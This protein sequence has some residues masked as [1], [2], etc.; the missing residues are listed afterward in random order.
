[1]VLSLAKVVDAEGVVINSP[2][3]VRKNSHQFAVK[4][5]DQEYESIKIVDKVQK[6][7]DGDDD[8]LIVKQVIVEKKPI[9]EFID[10]DAQ[11]VGVYNIIK[12]VLRTGDTSLLPIDKGDCN[13]DLVGAPS[14]LMEVKAMGAQAEQAFN[15]LPGEL[16][17][18][19]DMKAFVDSLTQE[20][21]D[22]F[23]K[24]VADRQVAANKKKEEVNENG[25]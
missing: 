17:K 5:F 3:A 9:Q 22:A 20:Q 7:G 18:G 12:Q 16:T 21:F 25:K 19:M 15:S 8:Y 2:F 24:S 1:M 4:E 6:V 10:A 14:T 13:V 11:S 23:I